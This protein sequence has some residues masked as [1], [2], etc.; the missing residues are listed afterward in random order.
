MVTRDGA[1]IHPA[2]AGVIVATGASTTP[3]A[4]ST[5]THTGHSPE[6]VPSSP[7]PTPPTPNEPPPEVA[8]PT[9]ATGSASA[10]VW[11]TI[12]EDTT[13][14]SA[15]P[16]P[17]PV[18]AI[19]EPEGTARPRE[20]M[21]PPGDDTETDVQTTPPLPT[22]PAEVS[23]PNMAA[24]APSSPELTETTSHD[25]ATSQQADISQPSQG[26]DPIA[27]DN[28]KPAQPKAAVRKQADQPRST[29][30][31][32]AVSSSKAA[33]SPPQKASEAKASEA[34][35]KPGP[36]STGPAE[37]PKAPPARRAP[38]KSGEAE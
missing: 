38:D 31:G 36:K 15:P 14:S 32:P 16:E 28:G 13:P 34:A 24:G 8:E 25:A 6:A 5:A 23:E 3:A 22:T 27:A 26:A 21:P 7:P 9:L 19:S 12:V 30:K 2:F 33:S 10:P 11:D 29:A 18:A 1:I 37:K 20:T 4:P 17:H 35:G